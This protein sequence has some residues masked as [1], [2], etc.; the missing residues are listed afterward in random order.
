MAT[1]L[2]ERAATAPASWQT[3][4]LNCA[5]PLSGPYCAA[6]GQKALPPHP[7]MR[8]LLHDTLE[9]LV[10][11]DGKIWETLRLLVTRPGALTCDALAGRRARYI[12]PL[13]L[14]LTC[15]VIYFLLAAVSPG[16]GMTISFSVPEPGASKVGGAIRTEMS[17]D[18][19]RAVI[20][21]AENGPRLMRPLVRRSLQDPA[22]LQRDLLEAWPKVLFVLLP[23]FAALLALFYRRRPFAAHVYFALHLHAFVFVAMTLSTIAKFARSTP[24][25]VAASL[26]VFIWISTYVHVA[27][28]RVYGG[29]Q[30]MTMMKESG[31]GLLYGVATVP[32]FI[33]AATWIAWHP[34]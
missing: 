19:R 33:A 27:L 5:A 14:Y 2:R 23:V 31:V 12:P 6:C 1:E 24:V 8:E 15:S 21:A 7:S 11:W 16:R 22:G 17:D 32:M 9:E 4:C 25:T 34:R 13:R 10:H 28:R 30:L 20:E 3:R 26:A 18:E 29:S